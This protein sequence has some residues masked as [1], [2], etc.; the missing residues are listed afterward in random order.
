VKRGGLAAAV[1]AVVREAAVAM[2]G[3]RAAAGREAVMA[4][5]M[6]TKAIT[7]ADMEIGIAGVRNLD[8]TG[9]R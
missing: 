1:T 5:I 7:A 8:E 2:T 9:K 3:A 6:M 4:A